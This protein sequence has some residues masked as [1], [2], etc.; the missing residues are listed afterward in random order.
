MSIEERIDKVLVENSG[1]EEDYSPESSFKELGMDSLDIIEAFMYIE[2][3]FG[4]AIG[5]EVWAEVNTP[6][7][8]ARVV[9]KEIGR[10]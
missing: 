9:A 8:A 7:Q 3:E 6:Q 1:V 4:I 2:D 5:D 10:L